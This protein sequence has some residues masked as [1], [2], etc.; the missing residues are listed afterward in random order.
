MNQRDF[1]R[2]REGCQPVG[3]LRI[4]SHGFFPKPFATGDID[5]ARAIY[6]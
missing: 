6:D 4:Q 3:P 2:V 5:Q 1:I